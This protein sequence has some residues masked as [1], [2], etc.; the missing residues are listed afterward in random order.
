MSVSMIPGLMA[1]TRI[2]SVATSRDKPTVKVSTA[3]LA[4]AEAG[5]AGYKSHS[6]YGFF[7]PRGTPSTIVERMDAEVAKAVNAPDSRALMA[8]YAK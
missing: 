3:A 4:A 7:A 2:P 8:K 6:W 1:L 5:I